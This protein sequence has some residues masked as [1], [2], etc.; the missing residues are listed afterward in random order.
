MRLDTRAC[1]HLTER[2]SIIGKLVYAIVS[3]RMQTEMGF[4]TR[5]GPAA[6][7]GPFLRLRVSHDLH[8]QLP[9][10]EVVC[11]DRTER[12]W[13][14]RFARTP[15]CLSRASGNRKVQTKPARPTRM[16]LCVTPF[17]HDERCR[18]RPRQLRDT[19]MQLGGAVR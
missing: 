12:I 17:D 3:E 9:L 6:R 10:L 11:C 8:R 4:G 1:L 2:D 18:R 15:E 19:R 13:L 5:H 16:L 14:R 7:L